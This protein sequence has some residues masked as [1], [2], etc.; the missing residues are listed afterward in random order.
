VQT[1]T[2]IKQLLADRGLSPKKSLGQNFLTDHN[3]IRRLV[4]AAAVGPSSTV[5]EVGPGTGALTEELL[6]RGCRVVASELDDALADLLADTL[7]PQYPATFT[8]IRGDC[9]AS[10]TSLNPALA[11]ALAPEP[12]AG[13]FSLVANLPYSAATP[14]MLTLLTRFPACTGLFVTIQSEVVDRLLASPDRPGASPRDY[15]SISVVA[16]ALCR[17]ERLAKLPPECFW[18]RPDVTSGMIAL[19]RHPAAPAATDPPAFWP[20]LADLTQLLFQQRRKQLGS[21]LRSLGAPDVP[22]PDTVRP[23]DRP[24]QVRVPDLVEL[25]RR[26]DPLLPPRD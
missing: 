24:E 19:T 18:P 1:L 8:L 21:I 5:L 15:G 23:T 16:Q 3:L 12:G 11:A 22:L 10:K 9:L 25:A 20:R 13:P 17:V 2:H 7:A 26:L 4:D 6:A 14:L